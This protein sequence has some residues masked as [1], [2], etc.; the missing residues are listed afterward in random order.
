[1]VI[2]GSE[3]L[4]TYMK[5]LRQTHTSQEAHNSVYTNFHVKYL[6]H[7]QRQNNIWEMN[8]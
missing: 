6:L 1:M 2:K 8:G 3:I 4:G 5:S 7:I